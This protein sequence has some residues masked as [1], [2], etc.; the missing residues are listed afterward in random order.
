MSLANCTV[1]ITLVSIKIN[2]TSIF[3]KARQRTLT[4]NYG[5]I[6]VLLNPIF[7]ISIKVSLEK[8]FSFPPPHNIHH[9]SAEY[10]RNTFRVL[11][12]PNTV[13]LR[14]HI[15]TLILKCGQ[16]SPKD[17]KCPRSHRQSATQT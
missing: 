17:T 9:H 12:L 14:K 10:F 3:H 7:S 13:I 1:Y 5:H 4:S 8:L 15:I 6:I 2:Y 16:L 11:Y